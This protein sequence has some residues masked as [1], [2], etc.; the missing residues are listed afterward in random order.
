MA[1]EAGG[2]EGQTETEAV[3][4]RELP[5]RTAAARHAVELGILA[6]NNS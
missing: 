6:G 4:E 2:R 5:A 3:R 1:K